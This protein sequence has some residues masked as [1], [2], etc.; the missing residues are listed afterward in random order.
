[1]NIWSLFSVMLNK[2]WITV[3]L[4]L[5][6]NLYTSRSDCFSSWSYL[7]CHSL[8]FICFRSGHKTLVTMVSKLSSVATNS[9]E[10]VSLS[11]IKS[12]PTFL[13]FSTLQF[14]KT[15]HSFLYYRGANLQLKLL[16]FLPV[17]SPAADYPPPV[18]R[19]SPASFVRRRRLWWGGRPVPLWWRGPEGYGRRQADH[20]A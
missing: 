2:P 18:R 13:I 12:N 1:M 15:F 6:V 17:Q 11:I 20:P 8:L 3:E 4:L 14:T 7:N 10:L 9:I 19:R 16:N 5:V